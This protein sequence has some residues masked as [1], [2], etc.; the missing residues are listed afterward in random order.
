MLCCQFKRHIRVKDN[1]ADIEDVGREGPG[2]M[3]GAQMI[4]RLS[5]IAKQ[6]CQGTLLYMR[7]ASPKTNIIIAGA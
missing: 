4:H 3:L 1:I 6:T 5:I 7:L 2:R